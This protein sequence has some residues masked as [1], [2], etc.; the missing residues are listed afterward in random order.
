[1]L[2]LLFLFVPTS[3]SLTSVS[4]DVWCR[5]IVM[6]PSQVSQVSQ[7]VYT[8]ALTAAVVETST[9]FILSCDRI[10]FTS[11]Y[12]CVF[13]TFEDVVLSSVM[14][15]SYFLSRTI[16]RGYRCCSSRFL[17]TLLALIWLTKQKI[18]LWVW[19]CG[20]LVEWFPAG[21]QSEWLPLR[22]ANWPSALVFWTPSPCQ[23]IFCSPRC[24]Q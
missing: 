24:Y 7:V 22:P 13:K 6:S 4:V 17:N 15:I 1:M 16:N 14:N 9:V 20:E 23:S 12:L 21:R 2:S 19:T 10:D 5:D 11:L 18:P 3:G 8:V